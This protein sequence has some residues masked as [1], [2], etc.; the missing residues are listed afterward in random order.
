MHYTEDF[1]EFLILPAI[2]EEIVQ[3]YTQGTQNWTLTKI[4]KKIQYIAHGLTSNHAR[5]AI[6][7]HVVGR[8]R[9]FKLKCWL[10][11]SSD[12][13]CSHQDIDCYIDNHSFF[14]RDMYVAAVK[15]KKLAQ[16]VKCGHLSL[17]CHTN[18][19][20]LHINDRTNL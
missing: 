2:N 10:N 1:S 18:R 15:L 14:V 6:M 12:L 19:I 17:F 20:F 8:R 13:F 16:I 3:K 7:K 11:C 4:I 5:K 9:I